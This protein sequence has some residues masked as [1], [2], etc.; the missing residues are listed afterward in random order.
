MACELYQS[1]YLIISQIFQCYLSDDQINKNR[2]S[3]WCWIV[4]DIKLKF[5]IFQGF[6]LENN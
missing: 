4:E 3:K 2:K 6:L 1:M 5:L